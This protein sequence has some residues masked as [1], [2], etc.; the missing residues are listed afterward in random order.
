MPVSAPWCILPSGAVIGDEASG[1]A[2]LAVTSNVGD[3][4]HTDACFGKTRLSQA[5]LQRR[6]ERSPVQF[7]VRD[8]RYVDP[9]IGL[10][11]LIL[12]CCGLSHHHGPDDQRVNGD[13][14]VVEPIV[15]PSVDRGAQV[16]IVRAGWVAD[17]AVREL[18]RISGWVWLWRLVMSTL[19]DV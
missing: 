14:P 3:H 16:G 19:A 1:L 15:G 7:A 2:R 8:D 11:D 12:E 4:V 17:E 9:T 6:C 13:V 10:A 5:S 18:E